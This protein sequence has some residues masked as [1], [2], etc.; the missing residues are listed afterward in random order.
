M[1]AI[2]IF[3]LLWGALLH[4][5]LWTN[6]KNDKIKAKRLRATTTMNALEK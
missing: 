1:L 3:C 2:L 5:K 6:V 4:K